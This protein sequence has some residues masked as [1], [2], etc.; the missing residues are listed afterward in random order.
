MTDA[1]QYQIKDGFPRCVAIDANGFELLKNVLGLNRASC[2]RLVE[3]AKRKIRAF[4]RK[5]P[6]SKVGSS[7]R[8]RILLFE[9]YGDR[10]RRRETWAK[11]FVLSQS[12]K[13]KTD[14]RTSAFS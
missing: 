7:E 5:P 2:R 6:S 1:E 3:D 14:H 4:P 10:N 13:E 11:T 9:L 12:G 8:D